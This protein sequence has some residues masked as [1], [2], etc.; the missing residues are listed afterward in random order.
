MADFLAE[1]YDVDVSEDTISRILKKEKISRK[2]VPR[3]LSRTIANSSYN[4]LQERDQKL[5]VKS[6]LYFLPNETMS[7]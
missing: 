1:E 2:K 4:E 5:F 6:G 3:I 7:N